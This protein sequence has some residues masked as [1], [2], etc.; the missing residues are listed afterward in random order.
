M[1]HQG[2]FNEPWDSRYQLFFEKLSFDQAPPPMKICG[3][4]PRVNCARFPAFSR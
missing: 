4:A 2:D 3:P 1:G